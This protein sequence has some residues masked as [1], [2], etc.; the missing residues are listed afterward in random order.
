MQAGLVSYRP[1]AIN[2]QASKLSVAE[3]RTLLSTSR[4]PPQRLADKASSRFLL[5]DA[6][7]LN[8]SSFQFLNLERIRDAASSKMGCCAGKLQFHKETKRQDR[9]E[10]LAAARA[11]EQ[12][13]G[14]T[15]NV[16]M[17]MSRPL[18][19]YYINASHNTYLY[20]DQLTSASTPL[21]VSRALQLGVMGPREDP[22]RLL[23]GARRGRAAAGLPRLVED[24]DRPEL[25]RSPMGRRLHARPG[26]AGALRCGIGVLGRRHRDGRRLPRDR[27]GAPVRGDAGETA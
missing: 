4:G 27:R 18:T 1:L 8:F 19:D 10:Y 24:Q 17:D 5:A 15:Q 2:S 9:N 12:G 20:G 23:P 7:Y 6:P 14:L 13:A 11:V 26:R 25:R 22:G 16:H 21:A 3:T